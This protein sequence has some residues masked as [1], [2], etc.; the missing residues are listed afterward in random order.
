MAIIEVSL[1]LAKTRIKETSIIATLPGYNFINENSQTQAE[2]VS[3]YIK[4][5]LKYLQN[6]TSSS[7]CMDVKTYG[8]RY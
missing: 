2:G 4:N 5:N 3:A 6:V 1:I 7:Q 8:W